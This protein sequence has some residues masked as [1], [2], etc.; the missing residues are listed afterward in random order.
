MTH[1]NL[2]DAVK[3]KD[4]IHSTEGEIISAG[5]IGTIVDLLDEGTAYLVELFGDW[6]KY[7]EAEDLVLANAAV[8]DSFRETIGVE[9]IYPEQIQLFKPASETVG[10]RAQLLTLMDELPEDVLEEVKD[11]AEFLKHKQESLKKAS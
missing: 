6:V 10:I 11:F 1:F 5:T 9:V 2:F 3:L 8:P 4:E 7:D